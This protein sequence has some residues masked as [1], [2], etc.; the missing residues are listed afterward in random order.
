MAKGFPIGVEEQD[1]AKHFRGT[2][3]AKAQGRVQHVF[4][5]RAFGHHFGEAQ[6]GFQG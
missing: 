5:A 4:Q 6:M 1:G 2:G 3:F